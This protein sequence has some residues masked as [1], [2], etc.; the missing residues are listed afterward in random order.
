MLVN[1]SISKDF[2]KIIRDETR[3]VNC[4]PLPPHTIPMNTAPLRRGREAPFFIIVR[5][6]G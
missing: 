2:R 4:G 1:D 5:F 3:F 6:A